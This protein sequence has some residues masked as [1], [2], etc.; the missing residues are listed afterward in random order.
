MSQEPWRQSEKDKTVVKR[1][2]QDQQEGKGRNQRE[3]N[4][5]PSSTEM[6]QG[7]KGCNAYTENGQRIHEF[8]SSNGQRS[9]EKGGGAR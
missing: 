4:K 9:T 2:S 3:Y 8:S 5:G 6:R 1:K 7:V